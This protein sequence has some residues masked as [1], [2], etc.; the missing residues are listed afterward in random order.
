VDTHDLEGQ[1]LFEG[2]TKR[3]LEKVARWADVVDVPEGYHLLNQGRL[4]HE[5]FVILDGKADVEREGKPL[6]ELGPGD[7]FG[8]IALLEHDRRTATVVASSAMRLMVMAT[9]EFDSMCHDYPAVAGRIT[10]V[11][12]ERRE[13]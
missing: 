9:R 8:E 13:H 7:F 11:F 3:D 12:R 10:N 6:A 4:P 2:L 1:P 5:F